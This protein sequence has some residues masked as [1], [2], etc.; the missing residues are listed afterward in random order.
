M[1]KVGVLSIVCAAALL[2]GCI[3]K[4]Y[5]EATKA[6]DH[7]QQQMNQ[8]QAQDSYQQPA[9][10]VESGYYVDPKPVSL[11]HGPAWLHRPISLEAQ[12]MPISM[13]M[14]RILR[15]TNV[16]VTYD[17]SV[18]Q[19]YLVSMHYTGTVQGA[20]ASLAA[21]THYH[22]TL[23]QHEIDWSAFQ[24]KTFNISFMPG[25]VNYLVGQAQGG[26][27]TMS[28]GSG[29]NINDLN[30]Q[31]YS[32]LQG[33]ISVWN[34]LERTLNELKSKDGRVYVS[35]STTSVTVYDHPQNV[36]EMAKYIDE[37]N[38]NLSEEVGI[39]V[40]VLEVELDKN[41]NLGI[42]WNA[43]AHTLDTTFKLTGNFASAT[44]LVATN[45]VG[46]NG[47]SAAG[48]F[49]IGSGAN[50]SLIQAISQQ[51]RVRVVTRPQVVTMNNNIASIRITKN[52][53]YI[54]SINT[55]NGENYTTTSIT[56]GSV[57]DGFTLYVLPKIQN[58]HVYMSISSSLSNLTSLEKVST[59]P[60]G[61]NNKNDSSNS[62]NT[63]STTQY[64]AIEV[65]TVTEK[66]FNQRSVVSSGSTLIIAGYKRL[67]DQT[68]S[69]KLFGIQQLGGQ[70]AKTGN[71]ETLV[72]IT[73]TIL[74]TTS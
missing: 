50:V 49:Q 68:Q 72:L 48:Q 31:E 1:K 32:N 53:G 9:V 6:I 67:Q 60:T 28:S 71:I 34:D 66:A 70:G 16:T 10:K 19:N 42:N 41:F 21:K 18:K 20:L 15:R 61:N 11:H 36:R 12:H 56:P 65:P 17:R 8:A 54:E 59:A 74:K 13:L 38:K 46:Q 64:S 29:D 33:A 73:P 51:G 37:L 26:N 47:N 40:Q 63:N 45:I 2:A 62:S 30:N 22:Y 4:P 55:T 24:T 7:T 23:H 44:D 5:K 58:R 57:T 35:Q 69:A 3:N 27:A 39:K 52:Q 43:V 25:N 14:D